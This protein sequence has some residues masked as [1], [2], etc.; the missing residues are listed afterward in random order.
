MTVY[1]AYK[2]WLTEVT[3][4]NR[5]KGAHF[6]EIDPEEAFEAGWNAAYEEDISK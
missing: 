6:V 3:A 1:E 4:S 2:A 5:F